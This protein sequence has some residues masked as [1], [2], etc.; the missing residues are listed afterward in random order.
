MM[1]VLFAMLM[2]VGPD[3]HVYP[4]A[5]LPA[6]TQTR[7]TKARH[8]PPPAPPVDPLAQCV[9]RADDDADAAIDA[10]RAWLARA[11]PGEDRIAPDRCLGQLLADGG[12]YGGAENAFADAV[13]AGAAAPASRRVPLMAL[14]G[15][16]ALAAGHS[17]AALDWYDRALAVPDYADPAGRSAILVDRA[18]A[19]VALGRNADAAASLEQAR[20]LAP[21]DSGVFLLSATLA[22]RM[23]DLAAAQA[24]IETAAKLNPRDPAIGLEA[25]VIAVLAG[26][27]LAARKSWNS[28]LAIAPGTPEADQ[29]AKYLA[30]LGPDTGITLD[31]PRPPAPSSGTSIPQG[32]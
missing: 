14:A 10:A 12:D 26:H 20:T 8:A 27:D 19:A 31:A 2:Q 22:R 3:P 11:K 32:R 13:A 21:G 6:I 18:R 16:A 7:K 28:V 4:Q 15:G 29:A 5:P 25:G 9:A 23:N 17:A 30:Q 24:H 1:P